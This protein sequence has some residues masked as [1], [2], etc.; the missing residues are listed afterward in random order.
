MNKSFL[1]WAG[2]KSQS[3]EFIKST[4]KTKP[5]RLIEPFAGSAVVSLN[6][7][8]DQYLICD[9]NKDLIDVF[10]S[11]K[12]HKEF[13]IKRCKIVFECGNEEKVYYYNRAR[14]N[15]LESCLEKSALF[16]YLNRHSF[17]GLCRYNLGGGFNVPFGRYKKVYFP[18]QEMVFFYKKAKKF[19]FK[20]AS[21]EKTFA[22]QRIGDLIYCDPP[23]IPISK[24][25]SFTSYTGKGFDMEMQK[26]LVKLAEE[27]QCPVLISNH[28][29][30]NITDVLY[31]KAK[32]QFKDINRSIS[33][34]GS[35]RCKVKEVLAVFNS[36]DN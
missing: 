11:L 13:F 12:K 20:N 23:Y 7:D 14:F 4:I 19:K 29:I 10:S 32:K 16:V 27:S 3:I 36:K 8:A 6:I 1:K 33:A 18:Q 31:G 24:T 26:T 2:G 25:A 30:P 5:K 17:N 21:F 35:S 9:H 34:S 22:E 15:D 28:W